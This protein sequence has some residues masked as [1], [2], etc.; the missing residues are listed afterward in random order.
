[1][2][3]AKLTEMA[4]DTAFGSTIIVGLGYVMESA[5]QWGASC[6]VLVTEYCLGDQRWET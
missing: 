4:S 5:A 2:R 1:M 6:C 3:I